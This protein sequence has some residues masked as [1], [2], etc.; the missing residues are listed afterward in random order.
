MSSQ[1][2]IEANRRNA[3]LSTGAKTPQGRC[4]SRMNAL[5]H[6]LTAQQ[7][8]LF[9]ETTEDFDKFFGELV[10]A[11][12]PQ[13]AIEAQLAERI[14]ICA[15][16][17]RRSYRIEAAL[18]ENVRTDWTAE[19]PALTSKIERL[20]VRVTAH[21]DQLSKLTRYE[22]SHERSLQRALFTLER[23]QMRRRDGILL[24]QPAFRVPSAPDRCG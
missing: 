4:A 23:R 15:W 11:L 20:F 17:L 24:T 7:I 8:V 3:Q 10:K 14:A 2:Q 16:R 22:A 6:G 5:K 19:S 13:D 21:E 18:F 9:D 1:L 12:N